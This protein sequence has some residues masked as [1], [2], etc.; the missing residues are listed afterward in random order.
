MEQI[1]KNQN[2]FDD[3]F[4]FQIANKAFPGLGFCLTGGAEH[5]AHRAAD[6]RR[7]TNRVPPFVV[8]QHDAFDCF[9]V[10]KFEQS[11]CRPGR[12]AGLNNLRRSE[13]K[14]V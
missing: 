11:F 6:L 3:F 10:V 4:R 2:L 12:L 7:Q 8:G 9:A 1:L 13:R 14:G 5:T